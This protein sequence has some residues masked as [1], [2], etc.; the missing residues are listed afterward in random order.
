MTSLLKVVNE[1]TKSLDRGANQWVEAIIVTSVPTKER[2]KST[3][4]AN[5]CVIQDIVTNVTGP[6]TR[7]K[8]L[9]GVRFHGE[10]ALSKCSVSALCNVLMIL[11]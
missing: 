3:V 11:V 6:T 4:F 7:W 10:Q 5:V 8:A 1:V 9:V 2:R